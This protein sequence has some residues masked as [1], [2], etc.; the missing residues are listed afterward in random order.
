MSQPFQ[1]LICT[2]SSTTRSDSAWISTMPTSSLS[3]ID[4]DSR[5]SVS[6]TISTEPRPGGK[7]LAKFWLDRADERSLSYAL[8]DG[9]M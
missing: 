1:C 9:M 3:P 2:S 8:F 7:L 4:W 5:S 6:I